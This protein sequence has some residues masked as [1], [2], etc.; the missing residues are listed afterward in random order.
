MAI[1]VA[2][3]HVTWYRYDRWVE[4]SPQLVRLRPAPHCRTP[5]RSY[6]LRVTPAGHFVNWQQDPQGNYLARLVFPDTV[7]ELR[8]EVDLV[9]ELAVQN[10]FD[11]F[12]EPRAEKFPFRYEAS[13]LHELAPYLARGALPELDQARVLS[14]GVW[15]ALLTADFA[16]NIAALRVSEVMYH[17]AP[18][19]P[20]S[21]YTA[22]DFEFIE[23]QNTSANPLNVAGV[24]VSQG[25]TFAFPN[26][27][28][29]AGARTVVVRNLAAFES[30]YGGG[31]N[32]AGT[33][34]GSLSND[35]EALTV[36]SLTGEVVQS[37]VYSD[38]W[39]PHTDGEGFSLVAIDPANAALDRS[40]AAGWRPSDAL[41]GG[42]TVDD[43][44]LAPGA[45]VIH[46]V[47]AHSPAPGGDWIELRNTTGQAIDVSGWFLSDTAQDLRRYPLPA[48]SILAAGGY[49][50]VSNPFDLSAVE[51]DVY[52]S[53]HDGHGNVAGYRDFADFGGSDVG[54]TFGRYVKSTGDADFT[55]LVSPTPGGGNAAPRV[56]PVVIS[57]VHY[58]PTFG[59]IEYLELANLS[60]QP[61]PL[62]DPARP[63]NA[64]KFLSG[65]NFTFPAGATIPAL[66]GAVV[67][68]SDPAAFRAA[69]GV[70]AHVPIYGPYTGALANDGEDVKLAR[71][72]APAGAIVPYILADKLKYDDA[73]PWPP[74]PD[75]G[76]RSLTRLDR[77]AYGNDVANWASAAPSPG[78]FAAAAA[79][80]VLIGG[81]GLLTTESGG[82]AEFS[83]VLD[84][85]PTADVT[86]ALS[87]SDVSEGTVAPLSLVFTPA[88]WHLAQRVTVTGLDDPADD[89]DVSYAVITAA[90][91]SADAGYSGLDP[92]DATLAN[93][94]DDEASIA[95]VNTLDSGA[96]SLRA[97]IL[98]A[99]AT[100]DVAETIVFVIP[101]L[102][103]HVIELAS[104]L[105]ELIGEATLEIAGATVEIG[106]LSPFALIGEVRR[107]FDGPIVL[108]GAIAS[109]DAILA[110]QAA[111]ADLAYIGTRFLA[112]PE[113]SVPERYKDEILKSS[114]ADIVYTDLFSGV[115]GNYLRHSVVS[116]GFDP[117]N[118]P[119][120]D[121]AKMNF[122]SGSG[123]EKKV[124][125]D[126]WSA[127]QVVGQIDRVMPVAE[128]VAQ[129]AR[130]YLTARQRLSLAS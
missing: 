109:G 116:A 22:D 92:A 79:G 106:T 37:F 108:S 17:P 34:T 115:H 104:A 125:R 113:A 29:A 48:D 74:D 67:V 97:A 66:G 118:L 91:V 77:Q 46:E 99:N 43:P 82:T 38:Q 57:E 68:S 18:P 62:F 42:P 10:P 84:R 69:H 19:P 122:G 119:R 83:V 70:P 98:A 103:P 112:T 121:P 123:A 9:A 72:G 130:E 127:G 128:V 23:L 41:H 30:R 52:L 90:A 20:G 100:V 39:Y 93:L 87:S 71:P 60:N 36:T 50:V 24:Q 1:H 13:Q 81:G 78:D 7:R 28:L 73:P 3:H 25:V 31:L 26:Q 88:N 16:T 44:G 55:E 117:A 75:G 65:V 58:H 124:W 56:G 54:A 63:G 85:P 11:F 15:S 94:D 47:L 102:G 21:P 12:L 95:V 35:G 45:V 86:I 120:S 14:G 6:S 80:I 32:V 33:F 8:L 96:G 49:L 5:I 107:F 101:G 89:G 111:G 53:N 40:S 27:T 126:I 59:G 105:P 64:W 76:G 4:L 61:A 110:A 129:L 2:L 114:A 51:A